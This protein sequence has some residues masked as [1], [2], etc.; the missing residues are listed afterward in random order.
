MYTLIR[1]I[2]LYTALALTL[3]VVMYALTGFVIYRPSWFPN[4]RVET[5]RSESLEWERPDF[6]QGDREIFKVMVPQAEAF[7]EAFHISARYGFTRTEKD[8]G[9]TLVYRK[10]G[11][12][13]RITA[14]AD[15]DS[16]AVL[17][18]QNGGAWTWNRMHQMHLFKG[19]PLYFLWGVLLDIVSISLILFALTGV[20]MWYTLKAKQRRLGW[21]L[22]AGSTTYTVGSLI[23]LLVGA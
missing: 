20:W 1:K 23:F 17:T 6:G 22:L 19:G 2:H 4:N 9:Y 13:E 21:I 15:R 16:I 10:P 7:R 18:I 14:Y 5:T 3:F 11:V 8:G 12:E